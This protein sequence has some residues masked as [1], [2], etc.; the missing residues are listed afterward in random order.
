MRLLS[1]LNDQLHHQ[2]PRALLRKA[3]RRYVFRHWRL[4]W[5]ERELSEPPPPLSLQ[6][7]PAVRV[8]RVT[9]HNVGAFATHFPHL[10][11]AQQDLAAEGHIGLMALDSQGSA[12]GFI[13]GSTR[14]YYDRHYY[15]CWFPIG[16]GEYFQFAGEMHRSYWGTALSVDMQVALW[17][18]MADQGCVRVVDVCDQHNLPA[19]KLHAR[20][21]YRER[22]R[23]THVYCL[24][25]RW[26]LVREQRYS[27]SRLAPLRKIGDTQPAMAS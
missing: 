20:M 23:V 21:Q 24:F 4:L 6:P 18:L 27:E 22:G 25:G 11:Q 26:R 17:R 19:M 9:V 3:I 1:K 8:E 13:W 5:T 2:G 12:V 16:D 10:R 15:G 7:Y 14:D